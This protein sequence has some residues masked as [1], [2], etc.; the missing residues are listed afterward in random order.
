MHHSP[1]QTVSSASRRIL[2]CKNMCTSNVPNVNISV[3]PTRP[4]LFSCKKKSNQLDF[5]VYRFATQRGQ[6]KFQSSPICLPLS[7]TLFVYVILVKNTFFNEV[8]KI[9]QCQIEIWLQVR[10][11]HKTGM[12]CYQFEVIFFTKIP[13]SF[14]CQSFGETIPLLKRN[15][16]FTS[17]QLIMRPNL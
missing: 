16:I 3:N 12:Y 2:E 11:D 14:L 8:Q 6:L 1:N 15:S 4:H 10:T 13:C 9:L 5:F 17:Q 7:P